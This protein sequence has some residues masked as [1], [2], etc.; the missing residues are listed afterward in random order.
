MTFTE[1]DQDVVVDG[2]AIFTKQH[3]RSQE[4]NERAKQNNEDEVVQ[5]SMVDSPTSSNGREVGNGSRRRNEDHHSEVEGEENPDSGH[6]SRS[7][8][9][10]K[11]LNRESAFDVRQSPLV[12]AGTEEQRLRGVSLLE[13]TKP[14][15]N[16]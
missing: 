13:G 4:Y 9:S 1:V 16:M 15:G 12:R 10:L 3:E 11:K 2:D 7:H 14:F 8:I 6:V 5:S